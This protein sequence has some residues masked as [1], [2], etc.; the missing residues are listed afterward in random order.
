MRLGGHPLPRKACKYDTTL[1]RKLCQ[2]VAREIE[3]QIRA[4][5][6]TPVTPEKPALSVDAEESTE[7]AALK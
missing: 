5:M 2:A 1:L 6:L 4:Q 3:D 7:E